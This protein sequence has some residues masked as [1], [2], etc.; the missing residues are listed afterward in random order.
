MRA[1]EGVGYDGRVID[2][3][4]RASS[5]KVMP[6]YTGGSAGASCASPALATWSSTRALA[7]AQ[8]QALSALL[9]NG[10]ILVLDG[11]ICLGGSVAPTNIAKRYSLGTGIWSV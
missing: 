2:L 3:E 1:F 9:L 11:L 10:D 7:L 4:S 6:R 8:S 5:E